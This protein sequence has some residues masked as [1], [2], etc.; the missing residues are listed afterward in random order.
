M[1]EVM[2]LDG[3]RVLEF[4][5]LV[6]A[7][8]VGRILADFG[9]D[10]I[11]IEPPEGD[12]LRHWGSGADGSDSWW[13]YA[14]SRNKRLISIDLK[15]ETGQGIARELARSSDVLIEN[16]RPGR[17]KRWHLGYEQISAENPSIVYASISGFGQTGPYR[18][19]A[20][21]GNIAESMGG[22][23]Y[24]TGFSDR[25]PVRTGISI[26]DELAALQAVVG[27]LAALHRR[28][29]DPKRHGDFVDVALTEAVLSVTE[30]LIPEYL[31]GGLVQERTANQLLRAAPSNIYP[32][33][34]EKWI[35]IG[36]NTAGTFDK[37]VE[38]MG[39]ADLQ[40]DI[41]FSTNEGRVKHVNEL[42]EAI[43]KWTKQHKIHALVDLL[44]ES[45]VPAGPV[46]DAEQIANDPQ[47]Q[48]RD[49]IQFAST[50]EGDRVG[51]L[52]VVPKLTNAPGR[53]R[54]AGGKVGQ[55]TDVVLSEVLK[56]PQDTIDDL[57]AVGA[58]K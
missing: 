9:A 50:A 18:D 23:R 21:F 29:Q 55:H 4:G 11:K 42:D 31:N 49:M 58:I 24:I 30:G 47:I 39:R 37:L 51:M 28:D 16:L 48:D 26:G 40:S 22:I 12:P 15:T 8:S 17:L 14:Q 34:D 20:G 43:A 13:W 36:A 2:A 32:T 19:R 10:V 6:A 1:K 38:V 35:A 25:P 45:G 27:I 52:N 56:Y 44:A 54:W 46:M 3:L 5:Q 7:P 53:I 57:R 41:R 33:A